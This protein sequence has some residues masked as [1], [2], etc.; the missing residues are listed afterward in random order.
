MQ[1]YE[2]S[3]PQTRRVKI[4]K[5]GSIGEADTGALGKKKDPLLTW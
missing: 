2:V 5:S 3:A 1:V 4:P